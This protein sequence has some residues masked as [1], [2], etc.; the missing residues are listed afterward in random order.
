[1]SGVQKK[2]KG[3]QMVIGHEYRVADFTSDIAS[4]TIEIKSENVVLVVGNSHLRP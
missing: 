4:G 3:Y 1:M 2:E